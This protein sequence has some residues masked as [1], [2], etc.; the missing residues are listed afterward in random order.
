MHVQSFCQGGLVPHL[1]ICT[2]DDGGQV[3]QNHS[4]AGLALWRCHQ[5]HSYLHSRHSG[6]GEADYDAFSDGQCT[7]TMSAAAG[8]P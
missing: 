5:G 6:V 4:D 2:L 3:Q 7:G 1:L 8:T